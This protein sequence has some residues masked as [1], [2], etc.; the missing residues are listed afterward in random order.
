MSSGIGHAI[1]N[2]KNRWEK[3]STAGMENLKKNNHQLVTEGQAKDS[4]SETI[5]LLKVGFPWHG[6]GRG[7]GSSGPHWPVKN[8]N[9]L[10]ASNLEWETYAYGKLWKLQDGPPK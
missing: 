7:N 8:P 2:Q 5:P 1:Y 4:G 6:R 9:D 3:H 10:P